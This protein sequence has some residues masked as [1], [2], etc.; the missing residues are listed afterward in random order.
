MS[1]IYIKEIYTRKELKSFVKFQLELYKNNPYFVPPLIEEEL[2]ILDKNIN[3]V[4]NHGEARYF[5]ALKDNKIVGRIAALINYNEEKNGEMKQRF[6]WF[7]FINDIKVT[8]ALLNKVKEIAKENNIKI[9]EGPQ[10]FSNMDKAGMLV[11]G[12]E[13]LATM[14][15]LYNEAYYPIFMEKLGFI[16][17]K[18]W[19]EY[20][21]N[22][23]KVLRDKINKFTHII[24]ERYSLEA[25]Q[26]NNKK[27]I[28]KYADEMFKLLGETYSELST[29]VPLSKQQIEYYKQ[30]YF[31]FLNHEFITCIR[32]YKTDKLMAFAILMPSFSK[33]LQKANGSLFP[34]GW[35]HLWKAS[36]KNDY[37]NF[38]L[39]GIHP[40]LQGKGVTAV[41]FSEVFK[42]LIKN[43]IKYLET[44]PE[45]ED[46]LNVQL[47]WKE[48][49]PTMHK[50][51]RCYK[52]EL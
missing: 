43:N 15:T 3:P 21:M 36:R 22:S 25:I 37:A 45:L 46:N 19:V 27:E 47:L 16:K 29:Y 24:K 52:I 6:G 8:E 40:T 51:R 4:F 13:K 39:I 30:K 50:R 5:L 7:D 2:N 48:F 9:L 49:N 11:E 32:N 42:S 1:E 17:S 12:F 14:I 33:A 23:P 10:G 18:D 28:I 35:F 41:V 20:E 31:T 26:F 34:F 38:Y 44:N